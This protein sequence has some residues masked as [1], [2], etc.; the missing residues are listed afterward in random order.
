[1]NGTIPT[2]IE[3][4]FG[5]SGRTAIVT[6]AAGG[7]GWN[8]AKLFANAGATVIAADRDEDSLRRVLD[9]VPSD[10]ISTVTYDQSD[11]ASIGTMMAK[12]MAA[13]GR[14]DVLVN[15]A[16]AFGMQNFDDLDPDEWDRIQAV[17]LKGVAFCCKEALAHMVR[18][19]AGVIINISSIAATRFV[20]YD[21]IAYATSKAGSI[22]LTQS[23]A[24]EYADRGIRINGVIPGAIRNENPELHRQSNMQLRGPL[25][26][27]NFIPMGDFGYPQDIAAACLYLAGDAGRYIT[28]QMV[29]VDGGISVR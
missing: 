5:L 8:I 15:C 27:P 20:L 19:K 24:R 3:T 6:G 17:N 29:T 10:S 2:T 21:N 9:A 14:I 28:G 26:E 16:A 13:H 18:C 7:I 22:A 11:P 25:L 1:M 12:V 23:L 4:L